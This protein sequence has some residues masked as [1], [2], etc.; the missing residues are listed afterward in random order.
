MFSIEL[1]GRSSDRARVMSECVAPAS[2]RSILALA[3]TGTPVHRRI[4]TISSAHSHP[5]PP[6]AGERPHRLAG[7]LG[8]KAKHPKSPREYKSSALSHG[9]LVALRAA[10][11]PEA[12]SQG[13]GGL[14]RCHWQI[15]ARGRTPLD[16]AYA[17]ADPSTT[18]GRRS[19]L[20]DYNRIE[21]CRCCN[22]SN[23]CRVP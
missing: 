23:F 18:T 10:G 6:R 7:S 12:C 22:K 20:G 21:G 11:R 5:E 13:K 1:T 17:G 8:E 9:G 2:H 14:D 3:F 4:H 15:R 16:S 19:A